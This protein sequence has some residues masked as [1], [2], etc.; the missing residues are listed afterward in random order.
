MFADFSMGETREGEIY[1]YQ[2]RLWDKKVPFGLPGYMAFAAAF[3]F[4]EVYQKG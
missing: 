4:M 2:T 1:L 3:F